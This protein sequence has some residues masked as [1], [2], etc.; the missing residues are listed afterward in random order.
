MRSQDSNRQFHVSNPV[1]AELGLLPWS[2]HEANHC[3][4]T[5]W[6][7]SLNSS[8]EAEKFT[9]RVDTRPPN[10]VAYSLVSTITQYAFKKCLL[11][12]DR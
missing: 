6:N 10:T 5:C 2:P 8:Y 4:Q 3:Q 12:L 1:G 9:V 11:Y 7:A